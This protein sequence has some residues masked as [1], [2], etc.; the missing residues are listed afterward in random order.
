VSLR[1]F[2]VVPQSTDNSARDLDLDVELADCAVAVADG[3]GRDLTARI[4]WVKC[5]M[6]PSVHSLGANR[7]GRLSRRANALREAVLVQVRD[8]AYQTAHAS[9]SPLAAIARV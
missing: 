2:V 7:C 1:P 4:P 3:A 6:P 9:C 5:V 8:V